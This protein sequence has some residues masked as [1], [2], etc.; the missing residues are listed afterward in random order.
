MVFGV[1]YNKTA[2]D[3][4]L[5]YLRDVCTIQLPDI[6]CLQEVRPQASSLP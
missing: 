1:I 5:E 6:V 2:D 3:W 4:Q